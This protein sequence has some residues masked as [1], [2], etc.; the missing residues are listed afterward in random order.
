ME[1][2]FFNTGLVSKMIDRLVNA[3]LIGPCVVIFFVGISMT[4][5][6]S[7]SVP[8][9]KKG[10]AELADWSGWPELYEIGGAFFAAILLACL[11]IVLAV[12]VALL[13][14]GIIGAI[15]FIQTDQGE[16]TADLD[17]LKK[18]VASLRNNVESMKIE[19]RQLKSLPSQDDDIVA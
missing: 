9:V 5:A 1:L 2:K 8:H 11:P 6:L 15:N 16:V 13:I 4:L 7:F 10:F 3:N 14:L 12:V 18:D 17:A 19:I